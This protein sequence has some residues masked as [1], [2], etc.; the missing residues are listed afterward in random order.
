MVVWFPFSENIRNV[1]VYYGI[2]SDKKFSGKTVLRVS[3]K[4][5]GKKDFE[6]SVVQNLSKGKSVFLLYESMV[7]WDS[8]YIKSSI[9]GSGFKISKSDTLAGFNRTKSSSLILAHNISRYDSSAIFKR[10]NLYIRAC[11]E[12]V[13]YGEMKY[14]VEVLSDSTFIFT[15]AILNPHPQFTLPYPLKGWMKVNTLLWWI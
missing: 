1:I 12:C 6:D 2:S 11:F 8:V 3:F 13:F 14:Y 5:P 10:E 4:S 9:Y 15:G 7:G